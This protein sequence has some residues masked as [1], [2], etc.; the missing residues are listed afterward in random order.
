V[1]RLYGYDNITVDVPKPSGRIRALPE[2]INIRALK[3]CLLERGYSEA[4]TY[5]FVDQDFQSNVLNQD[6]Q[7]PLQNPIS[8]DLSVMRQSLLPGLLRTLSYNY[9]RQQGRIRLFEHGMVFQN[10]GDIVQKN[11]LAGIIS[12]KLYE[13]QLDISNI[14]SEISDIKAD[15]Q[16][17]T[18]KISPDLTVNYLSDHHHAFHPGRSAKITLNNQDIGYLGAIHPSLLVAQDIKQNVYAF[19]IEMTAFSD[20]KQVKYAKF[21]KYPTI[22]RDIAILVETEISVSKVMESIENACSDLL[23]N[24]ELFDVYQGEGIDIEKKSLALGLTFQGTSSN[25]TDDEVDGKVDGVLKALK[26]EFGATLR[27]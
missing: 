25:L 18:S 3:Q 13:K 6:G 22:R 11:M 7:I 9:K 8:A 23:Q 2:M 12:G 19:E 24:L 4:I 26:K 21:S 16:A 27:E 1:A 10:R 5:S 20:K 15:F 17:L 14:S